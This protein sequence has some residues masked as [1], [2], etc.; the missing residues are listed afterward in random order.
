MIV[1]L[2]IIT[3]LTGERPEN[4]SH[5][6]GQVKQSEERRHGFQECS[7]VFTSNR[8]D[9]RSRFQMDAFR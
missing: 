7:A 5:I 1:R 4:I 9:S 2:V 3:G 8:L 6:C